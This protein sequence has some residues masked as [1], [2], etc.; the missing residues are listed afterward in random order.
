MSRIGV[1][2]GSARAL[3]ASDADMANQMRQAKK[4]SNARRLS[5]W[6]RRVTLR[7]SDFRRRG[8][9]SGRAGTRS[10]AARRMGK[11]AEELIGAKPPRCPDSRDPIAGQRMT[12]NR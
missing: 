6:L 4:R 3:F 11:V 12:V 7:P 5:R 10:L 2:F 1:R 9:L 8:G